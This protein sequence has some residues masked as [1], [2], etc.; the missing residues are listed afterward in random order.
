MTEGIRTK[1]YGDRQQKQTKFYTDRRQPIV[2][3]GPSEAQ[4]YRDNRNPLKTIEQF[5]EHQRDHLSLRKTERS[6]LK[7]SDHD[8]APRFFNN[9]SDRDEQSNAFEMMDATIT[10]YNMHGIMCEKEST[11]ASSKV[12]KRRESLMDRTGVKCSETSFASEEDDA[13]SSENAPTTAVVSLRKSGIDGDI[14]L[15]TFLPSMP[16][17]RP[18]FAGSRAEYA[19]SWPVEQAYYAND[20]RAKDR[21][22]FKLVRCMKESKFSSQNDGSA[23]KMY[24]HE[25]VEL[26]ISLSKGTELI[27]LGRASLVISGEE[28]LELKMNIPATQIEH[29][30]ANSQKLKN[31]GR[32]ANKYGYFSNDLST[33][34]FL[35]KNTTVQIG[36]KVVPQKQARKKEAEKERENSNRI[37]ERK[38]LERIKEL[39]E[40]MIRTTRE[41][42]NSQG[43]SSHPIVLEN[44]AFE[45]FEEPDF[46]NFKPTFHQTSRKPKLDSK[47][48]FDGIF[49]AAMPSGAMC[50]QLEKHADKKRDRILKEFTCDDYTYPSGADSLISSV[51]RS[52]DESYMDSN[53]RC[54]EI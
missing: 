2:T 6:L 42:M 53:M 47:R 17:C 10:V 45:S 18:V 9:E 34:Y 26:Q 35:D 38:K 3:E 1:F 51:S 8:D 43:R 11:N 30:P 25:T 46:E 41:N 7:N 36:L 37:K 5:S 50:A 49:C 52:F 14:T 32:K 48:F 40:R 54:Y 13:V 31:K 19:A 22:S 33:R 12:G 4:F 16:L 20:E 39:R 23:S 28:E 27:R 15:E 24:A 29:K 21:S 44:E